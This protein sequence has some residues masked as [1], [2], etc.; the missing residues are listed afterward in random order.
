MGD[1]LE[2]GWV[3]RRVSDIW[4]RLLDRSTV[5][6]Q[7]ELIRC[8][9]ASPQDDDPVPRAVDQ[10]LERFSSR[11]LDQVM[12]AL[13]A[14]PMRDSE[15]YGVRIN[16]ARSALNDALKEL[17]RECLQH[18]N[19][20]LPLLILDE[21]HHLKNP[22]TRFASLFQSEEAEQDASTFGGE[23]NGIFERMLFLTATPFQLGH[24]ELCQVLD[25][26]GSIAW[27]CNGAPR[28]GPDTFAK[29]LAEL[30]SYLDAAKSAAVRF[31]STYG[32]LTAADLTAD[33][34]LCVS[35]DEWWPIVQ[36]R[37]QGSPAVDQVLESYQET[38]KRMRQAEATLRPW[39][40]RHLRPRMLTGKFD[41]KPRRRKLPGRSIHS[42]EYHPAE[43]GLDL[44]PSAEL[45]FLLA[46]RATIS[47]PDSRPLFAEGLASSYEAFLHTRK[48][49]RDEKMG[50]DDDAERGVAIP[51]TRASEWYLA[52]L[53][54]VIPLRNHRDSATHPKIKATAE[55]VLQTWRA[56]E[57][58]VVFCH[59]IET[60]RALRRTISGL[61][62]DEILELGGQKLRCSPKQ[63]AVLLGRMGKRFFKT[64]SPIRRVCDQ[65]IDALLNRFA[66]LPQQELLKETIRRYI[67]TP[68][69]LVRFFPLTRSGLTVR[70]MHKAF[71]GDSGSGLSLSTVLEGFLGFLQNQCSTDEER[72]AYINE[73][74]STQ[75]GEMVARKET[76]EK[77]ELDG[78]N[79]RSLLLP[80]VRL[81]NGDSSPVTRRRLML[82]FNSPFF[83]EVLIASSVMAEGVDLQRF[84]RFVIHH[85]LDWNPSSLEQRTGRLDRIG[86]KVEHCGEPIHVYL[87][88]LAETQDEKMYRVVM[89]RERWF[90]V[91]MG[92]QFKVDARSTEA[93]AQRIPLP[94]SV[95]HELAFRLEVTPARP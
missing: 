12:D 35:V 63:A 29:T 47:S 60:G 2:M 53:E 81:V 15:N 69:F 9:I 18:L 83:P 22:E 19:F 8:G 25:R 80:N 14:V 51:I 62:H 92:E 79:A 5:D 10:A 55:R 72:A 23:L 74:S 26:F 66:A 41:G 45:P 30:R 37:N 1:L 65:E 58:A 87:P 31:D 27:N 34:N 32:R 70:A 59:F 46:A 61:L 88:Y 85:D 91:V 77:D 71:H 82:T 49:R 21:A 64:D 11:K 94:I 38:N 44:T 43:P 93:L 68:S 84:C 7:D 6:W 54:S 40:I 13:Y 89:D 16:V 20:R 42:D 3:E 56:G 76:F 28:S 52:Q 36:A 17:W 86:A 50:M 75:T 39:V 73:V 90:N 95:A 4:K 24:H 33:G 48:R 67:R 57:K 78:R